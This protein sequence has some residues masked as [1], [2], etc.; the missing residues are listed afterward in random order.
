MTLFLPVEHD[1]ASLVNSTPMAC[2]DD[3]E[4]LVR[5]VVDYVDARLNSSWNN[6]M[7][8]LEID[9]TLSSFDYSF[10]SVLGFTRAH[11]ILWQGWGSCGQYAIT[12]AYLM[13]RLGYTARISRFLD[14][15]HMW[16]EVFANGTWYIVDPWYIGIVYEN[17]HH[18]NRHLV[19]ANILAS[20]ENFTGYHQVSC[21][22]FNETITNCTS[23]HG[24]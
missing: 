15:D 13:N 5:K 3:F 9:N 11:V 22:Y 23:E 21:E 18:G 2:G 16:A 1:V 17:Q 4:C 8:V 7:A 6:P 20:L 10:L 24:Y 19:P 14:I 12:V